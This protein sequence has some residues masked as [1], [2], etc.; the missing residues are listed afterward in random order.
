MDEAVAALD[1]VRMQ[2]GGATLVDMNKTL[3]YDDVGI[4]I[5]QYAL[6]LC[7][8][9][10][11]MQAQKVN[12]SSSVNFITTLLSTTPLSDQLD[13]NGSGKGFVQKP[14]AVLELSYTC[15]DGTLHSMLIYYESDAGSKAN[16]KDRKH[17]ALDRYLHIYIYIY[18][19]TYLSIYIHI[20]IY[21][22]VHIYM[23][24]CIYVYIHLCI[25]ICMI[26]ICIYMY[27]HINK[28]KHIQFHIYTCIYK[29]IYV[30]TRT[31]IHVCIHV[32]IHV[33]T[34]TSDGAIL[35]SR[36]ASRTPFKSVTPI[37]FTVRLKVY[38]RHNILSGSWTSS[39]CSAFAKNE[40]QNIYTRV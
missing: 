30:Y 5:M 14:D 28:Y 34:C 6:E 19:Y 10:F 12:A 40:L 16:P 11:K 25:C 37:S 33:C 32:L 15:D 2:I 35:S 8:K 4:A 18:L 24:T 7:A 36:R 29:F 17:A 1:G 27:M 20:Y 23:Y 3:I 31:H 38:S 21:T 26:C 39:P 22:Y 9:H 13:W